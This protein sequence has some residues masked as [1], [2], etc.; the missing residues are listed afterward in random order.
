MTSP[1][2]VPVPR[3]DAEFWRHK[4]P[5]ELQGDTA[6]WPSSDDLEIGD[7]TA[8]ESDAFWAALRE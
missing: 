7:I 4:T 6:P 5:E 1:A 8:A 3:P 2:S